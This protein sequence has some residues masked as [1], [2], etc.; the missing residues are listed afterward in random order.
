VSPTELSVLMRFSAVPKKRAAARL[1]KKPEP[2]P[3][4]DSRHKASSRGGLPG[5]SIALQIVRIS[6]NTNYPEPGFKNK[7]FAGLNSFLPMEKTVH[8]ALQIIQ[9]IFHEK[10]SNCL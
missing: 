7:A 2:L 1:S 3:A 6:P 10:R 8:L 4:N 9:T 5:F